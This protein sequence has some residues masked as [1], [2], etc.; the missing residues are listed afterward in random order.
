MSQCSHY[1]LH[2]NRKFSCF[3]EAEDMHYFCLTV[4]LINSSWALMA[5]LVF[6]LVSSAVGTDL[7]GVKYFRCLLSSEADRLK[8]LC[9]SWKKILISDAEQINEE[10]EMYSCA[11]SVLFCELVIAVFV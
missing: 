6:L 1:S 4:C 8:A 2:N 10:G 9:L 7:G 5:S 11:I 3:S